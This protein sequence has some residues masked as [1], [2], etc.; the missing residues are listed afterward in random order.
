[1]ERDEKRLIERLQRGESGAYAELVDQYGGRVLALARRYARTEADAEDVTQEV[2]VALVKSIGK[3]RGDAALGTYVYRVALNHCLK[4]KER[5]PPESAPLDDLPVADA[6]P[7][8]EERAEQAELKERVRGALRGLSESHRDV[9]ILHELHGLTYAEC[10]DALGVPV[11]TVKSR[12]FHAFA[13]LR[14]LLG[15]YVRGEEEGASVTR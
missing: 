14:T 12:L 11:G 1:M 5:R 6:A 10:A 2:F 13:K 4:H 9:V 7:R 8:P 15:S 3:F